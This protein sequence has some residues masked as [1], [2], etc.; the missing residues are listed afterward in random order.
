MKVASGIAEDNIKSNLK[1]NGL[2][3]RISR[4]SSAG[5]PR[6]FHLYQISHEDIPIKASEMK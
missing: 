6:Q 1:F 3:N 4:H 2:L 5:P